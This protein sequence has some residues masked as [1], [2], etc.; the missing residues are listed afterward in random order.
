MVLILIPLARLPFSYILIRSLIVIPFALLLG[1]FAPFTVG[2]EVVAT[3]S[4]GG[5]VIEI[6]REGLWILLSLSLKSILSVMAT[7]I[8]VSATRFHHLLSALQFFMVP[9]FVLSVL[10]FL[11]RYLF[12]LLDEFVRI[13]RARNSRCYMMRRRGKLKIT[14]A[15][16]GSLFLRTYER[17]ER[18]YFA[19]LSRGYSGKVHTLYPFHLTL[20]SVAV[21]LLLTATVLSIRIFA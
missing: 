2:H 19:M 5:W 9:K 1:L 7:M 8:V 18:I 16:I 12:I 11:Y 10:M 17:S 3:W 14:G 4:I 13:I 20:T 21:F 6:K 15:L